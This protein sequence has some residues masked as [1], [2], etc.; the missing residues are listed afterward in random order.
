MSLR[1]RFTLPMTFGEPGFCDV[2]FD[3]GSSCQADI[4][5]LHPGMFSEPV[6]FLLRCPPRPHPRM[7]LAPVP[8]RNTSLVA[9]RLLIMPAIYPASGST[10]ASR[11]FRRSR[12][13]TRPPL[14]PY[15]PPSRRPVLRSPLSPEY[16]IMLS[17]KIVHFKLPKT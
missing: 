15:P 17:E 8:L 2:L 11:Q 6:S 5:L 1:H 13:R 7:P 9:H 16:R 4:L 14:F 3:A 10:P 12:I